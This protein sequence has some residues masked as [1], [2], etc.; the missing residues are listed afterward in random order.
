MQLRLE[1]MEM[2]DFRGGCKGI[3]SA[4]LAEEAEEDPGQGGI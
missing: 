3:F 1:E 2:R 4:V